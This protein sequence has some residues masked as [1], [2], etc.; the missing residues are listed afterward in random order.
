MQSNREKLSEWDLVKQERAKKY[1][2][3]KSLHKNESFEEENS[4]NNISREKA[5]NI[6]IDLTN[7][8]NSLQKSF[9][10][11]SFPIKDAD[12]YTSS[13]L[14]DKYFTM[15]NELHAVICKTI[16]K[17]NSLFEIYSKIPSYQ[18]TLKNIDYLLR[19]VSNALHDDNDH[20][21][22]YI[23]SLREIIMKIYNY[24]YLT[25]SSFDYVLAHV[26]D[27]NDNR[28]AHDTSILRYID[29]LKT[30]L[31]NRVKMPVQSRMCMDELLKQVSKE[32]SPSCQYD[33]QTTLSVD[34]WYHVFG[35]LKG[36]LLNT[37][38]AC[39]E[40]NETSRPYLKRDYNVIPKN[41]ILFQCNGSIRCIEALANRN[42]A[43]STYNNSM[44]TSLFYYP[45]YILDINTGK[46]I[47]YFKHP[48]WFI[49]IKSMPNGDIISA[50]H[51]ENSLYLW[52]ANTGEH[53]NIIS[54]NEILRS[55]SLQNLQKPLLSNLIVINNNVVAVSYTYWHETSPGTKESTESDHYYFID[56]S[57]GTLIKEIEKSTLPA[58]L[59]PLA[60]WSARLP[61]GDIAKYNCDDYKTFFIEIYDR[62]T[63][64][65]K[66]RSPCHHNNNCRL[67]GFLINP[68]PDGNLIFAVKTYDNPAL[69]GFS[70]SYSYIYFLKFP[71]EIRL[72]NEDVPSMKLGH[73]I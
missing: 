69:P 70:S 57:R 14:A 11:Y 1:Y 13:S 53:K 28:H 44:V 31:S 67:E 33:S 51:N 23:I 42:L 41:T 40:F 17:L 26:N 29:L 39:R 59:L 7:L 4:T 8:L 12:I 36:D 21:R 72:Q 10:D 16:E 48:E 54:L 22:L 66:L 34:T 24:L 47:I 5:Q 15:V 71:M 6:L 25:K 2:E 9:N 65:C 19:R 32:S 18:Y 62:I 49:I 56:I 55:S 50:P 37:R 45:N 61:N 46:P 30:I 58:E 43:I 63:G 64:Q 35:F 3:Q 60:N 20:N 27:R 38:L 73:T 52:D 68:L